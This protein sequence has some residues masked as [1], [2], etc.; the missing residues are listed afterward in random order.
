MNEIKN[1]S[2]VKI[3]TDLQ[4]NQSPLWCEKT[5]YLG[6]SNPDSRVIT[7][8]PL[9][10]QGVIHAFLEL[11]GIV[12]EIK[13]Y[14]VV[15]TANIKTAQLFGIFRKIF[16]FTSPKQIVLE[17][18]LDEEQDTFTWK[19]KRTLQ[20]LA[21]SSVDLIFVSSTYEVERYSKRLGISK[22]CIRFLP[23][24]TDILNP[25]LINSSG[26]YILSAGKTGRDYA[27][28]ADAVAGVEQRVVLVTDK[29]SIQKMKF[30]PNVEVFCD[31]PYSKY[32]DLLY[33]CRFVVVPLKKLVKSTG[34]VAILEAMASGKPV[35]ATETTGTV[36]YIQPWRN[37]SLVPIGD[38]EAL[39]NAM[40]NLTENE[41]LSKRLAMN[42]MDFVLNNC[43][44]EIYVTRILKSAYEIADGDYK[45]SLNRR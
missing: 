18:M 11:I 43:T 2:S 27:T 33:Q 44:F 6:G 34:Q 37:G 41:E 30:P 8:M 39:R 20:R 24:H 25:R 9:K 14:D 1:N 10:F 3:L 5:D 23:F 16:R 40:P 36:D 22:D 31:I 15:I 35:I 13:K 32:L 12:K 26:D 7:N 21:F 42:A 28:L 17:L 45:V 19:A 29:E 38:S 4:I